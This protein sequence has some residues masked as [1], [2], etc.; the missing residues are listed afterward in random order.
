MTRRLAAACVA[1][2]A[3]LSGCSAVV[4]GVGHGSPAAGAPT[5]ARPTGCPRVVYPAAKLT[6]DCLT[7]GLTAFYDG[8]VWP[9]AERK[10]VEKSTQW[11]LEEGAGHWGS[12]VNQTLATI[13]V[14][15]R[16]RMIGVG[17]YGASP[18]IDTVASR[19]TTVDGHDAYLLQTTFTLNPR[20]ARQDGTKVKQEK[21]WIVAIQVG[22]LDV[23]LWYTSVPDLVRELWPKVP[24]VIA[25]IKVG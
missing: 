6:F 10:T 2:A 23:S 5:P 3:L 13:A 11:V 25:S 4:H 8:A 16:Q 20:W 17:G 18:K 22:D 7:T 19:A 14:T 21:L 9:V 1:L 12:P 24:S 15:V